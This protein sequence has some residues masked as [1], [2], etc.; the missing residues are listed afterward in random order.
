MREAK[1]GSLLVLPGAHCLLSRSALN[2]NDDHKRLNL[3]FLVQCF[4]RFA[5]NLFFILFFLLPAWAG[6][7][8]QKETK[9]T[10]KTLPAGRN[11]HHVFSASPAPF[12]R[13]Y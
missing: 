10:P 7:V 3:N 5:N 8:V 9:R 12:F 4:N 13:Q 2:R 11:I 1:F 6:Q